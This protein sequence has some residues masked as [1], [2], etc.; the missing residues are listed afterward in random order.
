MRIRAVFLGFS[1]VA[2]A[3]S[4]ED[5]PSYVYSAQKYDPTNACL[6]SYSPIEVVNGPTSN[7]TCAPACITVNGDT[8]VST[9][10]PPLPAIASEGEADAS[11]CLEA[12]DAAAQEVSCDNLG[13]GEEEDG[14][15]EA[16]D[17]DSGGEEDAGE[18]AAEDVVDA[19]DSG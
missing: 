6:S 1:F 17:E 8:Y 14:G 9:Q 2:F 12:L 19:G 5:Q 18:D 13:G 4:C 10:C 16:G 15:D 11:P 3:A 7:A